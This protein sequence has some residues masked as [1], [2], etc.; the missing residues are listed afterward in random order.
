MPRR[1]VFSGW[2]SASRRFA[3]SFRAAS[4]AA[5]SYVK[6]RLSAKEHDA[7]DGREI[8]ET[9]AT[10]EVGSTGLLEK[11]GAGAVLLYTA[12]YFIEELRLRILGLDGVVRSTA[13]IQYLIVAGEAILRAPVWL[14]RSSVEIFSHKFHY[15]ELP[16]LWTF[17]WVLVLGCAGSLVSLRLRRRK[18]GAAIWWSAVFLFFVA[19]VPFMTIRG[20]LWLELPP[21]PIASMPLF[22]E[23]FSEVRVLLRAGD[24]EPLLVHYVLGLV[25]AGLLL[26]LGLK[27][28]PVFG[29]RFVVLSGWIAGA[30]VFSGIA[31]SYAVL[32]VLTAVPYVRLYV[33]GGADHLLRANIEPDVLMLRETDDTYVTLHRREPNPQEPSDVGAVW[34]QVVP[35]DAVDVLEVRYAETLFPWH[36]RRR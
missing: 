17:F 34:I 13:S 12:G 7:A 15:S 28:K 2:A 9:R 26:F 14:M 23:T 31:A 20:A 29:R 19:H 3:V 27:W 22:S 4:K 8:T 18:L 24:F 32:S 10:T 6:T 11:V 36:Y 30:T 16:L 33:A 1:P 21:P 35:K 25:V 5:I